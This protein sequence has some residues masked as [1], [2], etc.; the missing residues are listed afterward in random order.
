VDSPLHHALATGSPPFDGQTL[1]PS[2]LLPLDKLAPIL[3]TVVTCLRARWPAEKPLRHEDWHEHDGYITSSMPSTWTDLAALFA[4]SESLYSGCPRDDFVRVGI[5]AMNAGFYLRVWVPDED[6]DPEFRPGRRGTFDLSAS[7]EVL[8]ELE[9]AFP[10]QGFS[11]HGSKAY[12]E[13]RSAA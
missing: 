3:A 2:D 4:S 12:F 6:D 10:E 1:C 11:R 9:S 7:E 13:Q 8:T 5:Y